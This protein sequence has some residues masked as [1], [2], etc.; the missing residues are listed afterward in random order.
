M[1]YVI[2]LENM[3]SGFVAVP[4]HVA[5]MVGL[6]AEALAVLV[7]LAR[8]AG[9][10]GARIVRVGAVCKRFGFGKDRWQRVSREL[11]AVGSLRDNFGRTAD[12][13]SVVRSLV[14]GWPKPGAVKSQAAKPVSR[15]TRLTGAGTCEPE[16]PALT[17]DNPAEVSRKTRLFKTYQT[18]A[19]A[20]PAA[21]SRAKLAEAAAEV[22]VKSTREA[23]GGALGEAAIGKADAS[24]SLGLAVRCPFSGEW[25]TATDWQ[26]KRAGLVA[27]FARE[28]AGQV[29]AQRQAAGRAGHVCT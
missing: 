7:F 8:F 5:D 13:Q 22:V 18:D 3:E 4:N 16:N 29:E 27:E 14:V 21:P 11:R 28:C 23:E 17:A 20:S 19:A 10:R 15:K 9:G 25:M 6:S 2:E 26:A 12:G 24:A 1:D